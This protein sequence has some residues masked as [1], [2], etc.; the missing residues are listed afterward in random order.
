MYPRRFV[1]FAGYHPAC[2][3]F[4]LFFAYLIFLLYLCIVNQ[5]SARIKYWDLAR[6]LAILLVI[7]YHVPLYIR[8]GHPWAVEL[9][10]PHVN[11]GTYILPF[12]MPVFFIISG[13]FTNT[14]KSYGSFLWGDVKHLLGVGLLLT[15]VN[16]LIQTIGLQDIGILRWFFRSLFSAKAVDLILSNWFVSAIFFARQIYYAIDRL[17]HWLAKD[18]QSLYW[19]LEFAL[20]AM[21]AIMGIWLEPHAPFND[22]WYYCQGLVFAIFI[23]FGKLLQQHPIP[24]SFLWAGG[25]LYVLLMALSRFLGLSTLEYGM[26]NTS[27]TL[28]HWPFYM[29]L[30]LSGSALLVALAQTLNTSAPLEFI[31]RHSLVFYI[32]QGGILLVTSTL[33]GRSFLPDTPAHI[34]AY[35]LI[36]WLTSLLGLILIAILQSALTSVLKPLSVSRSA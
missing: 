26:I 16:T 35:I 20:L 10:A 19:I 29:L 32:P 34:W 30:A 8:I 11:A 6:G 27:F 5:M 4:H 23:A 7:F 31:G 24:K 28:A 21:V 22:H 12:F 3:F 2:A 17:A 18:R 1:H 13:V 25:G 9:T 14:A 33:L 15:F 36:M